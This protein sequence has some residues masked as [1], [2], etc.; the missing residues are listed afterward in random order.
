M[1]LPARS[2]RIPEESP[3]AA[4]VRRPAAAGMAI[5]P[6]D[7]SLKLPGE[8]DVV[9]VLEG[10]V[11]GTRRNDFEAGVAGFAGP[12]I[13]SERDDAKLER[14]GSLCQFPED[15]AGAVSGGIVNSDDLQR[16]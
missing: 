6:A 3:H 5:H 1:G 10:D 14:P 4:A 15:L 11:V 7:L 2:P 9:G 13:L 12:A 16:G 8:P